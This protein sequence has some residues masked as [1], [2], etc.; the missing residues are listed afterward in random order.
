MKYA[1]ALT[2]RYVDTSIE[3][4]K[5]ATLPIAAGAAVGSLI[6][7]LITTP[8]AWGL[9]CSENNEATASAVGFFSG[10]VIGGGFGALSLPVTAIPAIGAAL[11]LALTAIIA[12]P[13]A[14]VLDVCSLIYDTLT[15]TTSDNHVNHLAAAHM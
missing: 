4:F 12:Y 6:G 8:I 1:N 14:F 3:L 15:S 13:C 11:L 10:A 9:N 5:F 7:A 2:D